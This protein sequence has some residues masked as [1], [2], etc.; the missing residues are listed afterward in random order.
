ME[1]YVGT[2]GWFYEWNENKSFDWYLSHSNLNTVELNA[3]FYRFP[4]PNQ[5]KRWAEK[6][7][8]IRFS[9]KVHRKI[10]HILR[11]KEESRQVYLD[12]KRLFLPLEEKIDFYLFQMPPSFSTRFMADRVKEFFGDEEGKEKISIEFRNS[13]WFKEKSV[14]EVEK[15]GIAFVSVDSPDAKSFIVK[16]NGVI[17]LRLHGRTGWYSHNYKKEE[18]EDIAG[19]IARLKPERVYAYFNNNHNMLSNARRFYEI[20]KTL[21]G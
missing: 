17:Y 13:D 6:S 12:F 2:S 20:L 14:K 9:V 19:K 4:F 18:L 10:T 5:I 15:L 7:G 11:L 1:I 21:T 3:S 8:D 16:T